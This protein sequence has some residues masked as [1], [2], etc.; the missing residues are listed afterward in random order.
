MFRSLADPGFRDA[1]DAFSLYKTGRGHTG[2][3]SRAFNCF[4][5][6]PAACA[7]ANAAAAGAAASASVAAAAAG[8]AATAAVPPAQAGASIAAERR[9]PTLKALL[10]D[11]LAT[12]TTSLTG[13]STAGSSSE[14][15]GFAGTGPADIF[16]P[17]CQQFDQAAVGT[18]I[19]R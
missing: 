2:P 13:A 5:R 8:A 7:A 1:P 18:S 9:L 14:S 19:F 10:S 17:Y 12:S 6:W 3:Y 15:T 16:I 4:Y 11:R